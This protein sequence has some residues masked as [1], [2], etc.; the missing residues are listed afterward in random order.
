MLSE[1]AFKIVNEVEERVQ[2]GKKVIHRNKNRQRLRLP[3]KY[4]LDQSHQWKH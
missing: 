2:K 4:L 1:T 3:S